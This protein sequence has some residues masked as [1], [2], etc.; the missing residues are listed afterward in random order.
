M[1]KDAV[2]REAVYREAQCDSGTHSDSENNITFTNIDHT[3]KYKTRTPQERFSVEEN[4][5]SNE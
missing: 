1:W 3:Q 5:S 4:V 2:Y